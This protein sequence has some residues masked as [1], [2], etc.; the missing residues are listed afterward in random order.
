MAVI[1]VIDDE[2]LLC[3]LLKEVLRHHGHE[4]FVA[5]NGQEGIETFRKQRPQFTLLDLHLPDMNGCE[6]LT[7]IRRIDR[8]SAVMILTGAGTDKLEQ[9]ARD[10]GITDFLIKG[11][12]YDDLFSAVQRGIQGSA[13]PAAAPRTAAHALDPQRRSG[14]EQTLLVV[15]DE[16]PIRD[17]LTQDLS[18]QGY[19]VLSA[20]DGPTALSLAELER[21]HL[22]VLDINMPGMNGVEVLRTLRAKHYKGD[23]MMLTG[24]QD[25]RLL[26]E[27]LRL[28]AVEI[29]GKPAP[30]ERIRLAVAVSLALSKR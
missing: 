3:D 2:V 9:E 12:T 22:I 21:P 26:K 29:L 8:Q 13:K 27:A 17:L 19:R 30:L 1:L 14:W 16:A 18:Q 7:Q 15:D 11:L 23:V 6:V 20:H 4:V 10:L 5:Y 28:G 24:V 25:E